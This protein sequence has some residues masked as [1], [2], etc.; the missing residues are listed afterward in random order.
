MTTTE[1]SALLQKPPK[2]RPIEEDPIESTQEEIGKSPNR[3]FRR[4]RSQND[5]DAPIPGI[6]EMWVRQNLPSAS[7]ASNIPAVAE[8]RTEAELAKPKSKPKPSGLAALVRKTDPRKRFQRAVSLDVDTTATGI[9]ERLG[10][11][12]PLPSPDTDMGPWSTEAFDLFDWRP[13]VK[14][15]GQED[16]G[17]GML[18]NG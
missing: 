15:G 9:P 10:S 11:E 2:K 16:K 13:P 7:K 3:S 14:P 12:S 4:V 8:A 1:L 5:T 6:S 17:I 18:V